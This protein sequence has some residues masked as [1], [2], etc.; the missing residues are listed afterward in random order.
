MRGPGVN[1][2]MATFALIVLAVSVTI[3]AGG[4]AAAQPAP[5]GSITFL[6][7]HADCG[8]G[9][10][11]LHFLVNGVAIGSAP[12]RIGCGCALEPSAY[13]FDAPE[14]LALLD[15]ATCNTVQVETD[16]A[17]DVWLGAVG[18]RVSAPGFPADERCVF[19]FVDETQVPLCGG[20]SCTPFDNPFRITA[21][22]PDPDGDTI[23]SG[24]GRGCDN[25]TTAFN[26]LQEDSDGDGFGD[27][28]D[29]CPGPGASDID[30]DGVC[31]PADNCPFAFNPDQLDS[32]GD[33]VGDACDGCTGP[34]V[35]DS[36]GDGVCD[37]LDNCIFFYDPTQSDRDG[38]GIGDGCDNC[39]DVANASQNDADRD[40]IGD[41]CDPVNCI[42]DYDR[43]GFG[44]PGAANDCP[45]DNCPFDYNPDQADSDGDGIGDACDFCDGPGDSDYDGDGICTQADNCPFQ[46]NPGQEDSDHDGIGDACDACVGNGS[47]DSDGD[48][49]CDDAD[50]CMFVANPG[51]E[52][53]DGDGLGDACDNCPNVPN[54]DLFGN[55]PDSDFDG[56]GDA[57]DPVF[58]VDFDGDGT[59]DPRYGPGDC[60]LDNC[61]GVTN[62]GQEDA[63]GDG[64]GDACD[65]CP[66]I[67]NPLQL[68]FDRDGIGDAC[69]PVICV[70]SD[71]DGFGDV[72]GSDPKACPP[73]NC[74]FTYNPDQADRDHDGIG[75]ACDPCPDDATPET[76]ADGVCTSVDN[77]PDRPN[78]GQEDLDHDGIGDECDLCTDPDGDGFRTASVPNPFPN[79]CPIDNCPGVANPD[80]RDTDHD[81]R[82]DACDPND[83]PLALGR[84]RVWAPLARA[85]T[86]RPRGR[87]ELRGTIPLVSAEDRF[88]V[89]EGLSVLVRDGRNLARTFVFAP[90]ECRT[91]ASGIMRCRGGE[92]GRLV[93]DVVPL[94]KAGGR[95]LSFNLR[96]RGLDIARP[97]FAPLTVVLTERPGQRFLGTDRVGVIET[98]T[99]TGGVP[100][101]TPYGSARAAFLRDPGASLFDP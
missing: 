92:G 85:G 77:C 84:A 87:I 39:P 94:R 88:A 21:T 67:A 62:P 93:A 23:P 57:C 2:R 40:G 22:T 49:V 91:K 78:P 19:D 33:G 7:D 76:D 51:Q 35:S 75:D 60:P 3:L 43:D 9:Q 30:G 68:D 101:G 13:V 55:Q 26:P 65:N 17:D 37:Q 99:F 46:F 90:A 10:A 79:A 95:E 38:D 82:G 52:D 80:Q 66:A 44:Y 69:D 54:V 31:E 5:Q 97:F 59:Q 20:D 32:D 27:A 81:L 1:G 86:R 48:G 56:I 63:D 29:T 12:T 50:N 71:R 28:C 25:C 64:F 34:G 11:M 8:G 41:A 83:G 6:V 98:C 72:A 42:G 73:D 47:F 100:C 45:D 53:A 70:D 14:V 16:P 89:D 58:C 96:F 15:P 36:D 74:P 18:V 24:V 4:R 61:P